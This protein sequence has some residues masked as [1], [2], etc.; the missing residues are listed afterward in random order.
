MKNL[1]E[2]WLKKIV[3]NAF[4]RVLTVCWSSLVICVPNSD[5]ANSLVL[6]KTDGYARLKQDGLFLES[7]KTYRFIVRFMGSFKPGFG[8]HIPEF[9]PGCWDPVFSD[10]SVSE[11]SE[12]TTVSGL[13]RPDVSSINL[14]TLAF[15]SVNRVQILSVQLLDTTTGENQ[16]K[17]ADFSEQMDDW[18]IDGGSASFATY[19][20]SVQIPSAPPDQT[21]FDDLMNYTRFDG[22]VIQLRGTETDTLVLLT[23]A[24]SHYH[25]P[26]LEILA[27]QLSLSWAYYQQTTGR[28]P[29]HGVYRAR[30]LSG[31]LISKPTLAVV[32][33]TCGPGCGLVG[34]IGIE[35]NTDVWLDTYNHLLSGDETRGVFEYEMGR[36][37]W[38]YADQIQHPSHWPYHYATAFATIMGYK[39][40]VFAG[41]TEEPGYELVDWVASYRAAFDA[42]LNKPNWDLIWN[43]G[44]SSEKILGGLW[45]FGEEAFGETYLPAFF[46]TLNDL[47]T[48]SQDT[49]DA[50]DNYV[51]AASMAAQTDLRDFFKNRLNFPISSQLDGRL[52]TKGFP[53]FDFAA[54]QQSLLPELSLSS[55]TIQLHEGSSGEIIVQRDRSEGQLDFF[56]NIETVDE[57]SREDVNKSGSIRILLREG[58]TRASINM[59]AVD[60]NHAEASEFVQVSIVPSDLFKVDPDRSSLRLEIVP[61]DY[62][63]NQFET[64]GE[65]S[66]QQ[67]IKNANAANESVTID[68]S[69]FKNQSHVVTLKETLIISGM[70][71][72]LGPGSKNLTIEGATGAGQEIDGG[73]LVWVQ[74]A[75]K[76]SF[77]RVTFKGGN[78]GQGGGIKNEGE[79]SLIQV[80]LRDGVA[81][82]DGGG[83]HSSGT[84][85]VE[86]CT[87]IGNHAKEKG[88]AIASPGKCVIS[89]STFFGN[90]SKHGGGLYLG[91]SGPALFHH[92]TV[93]QN[94]ASELGGGIHSDSSFELSNSLVIGNQAGSLDNVSGAVVESGPNRLSLSEGLELSQVL[95]LEV[96]DSADVPVLLLPNRSPA[97]NA[98]SEFSLV[99]D[100]FDLDE[101]GVLNEPVPF[102]Q[103]GSGYFRKVGNA[104]DLGAVESQ[105]ASS[106]EVKISLM[107]DQENPSSRSH[108]EYFVAFSEP[109]TVPMAEQFVL[110]GSG[111]AKTVTVMPVAGAETTHYTVEIDFIGHKGELRLMLPSG[112]V[113]DLAGNPNME[114]VF[115]G[116][117]LSYEPALHV[118]L[119]R[120]VME[121][122]EGPIL[123]EGTLEEVLDQDLS[124]KCFLFNTTDPNL[125]TPYGSVK[126]MI[127]P[128]G[129]LRGHVEW[130]VEDNQLLEGD[131]SFNVELESPAQASVDISNELKIQVLEDE[132]GTFQFVDQTINIREDRGTLQVLIQFVA[133]PGV[134]LGSNTV[135]NLVE[136]PSG[137]ATG[138]GN[139]FFLKQSTATFLKGAPGSTFSLFEIG[140]VDD[141]L[142]ERLIETAVFEIEVAGQED[143]DS[144]TASDHSL[145]VLIED[146]DVPV[147]IPGFKLLAVPEHI[148]SSGVRSEIPLQV[149]EGEIKLPLARMEI[150]SNYQELF[151]DLAVR[152][153]EADQ[154][155]NVV[156]ET[157]PNASGIAQITLDITDQT[158]IEETLYFQ[159][160]VS[161]SDEPLK[162]LQWRSLPR[163]ADNPATLLI[164]WLGNKKL[165][166]RSRLNGPGEPIQDATSPFSVETSNNQHF[167]ELRA[168]ND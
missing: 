11:D 89:N 120:Q 98:G 17:N 95:S 91:G 76:V 16:I 4:F 78:A 15:W 2:R 19:D 117:T 8:D 13:F 167:F 152:I 23:P 49:Q 137:T 7:G 20:S 24:Q 139:D 47:G 90:T 108:V 57:T 72:I 162:E 70:V 158:G 125:A 40:G 12:I 9:C 56:V 151:S 3:L 5:A 156:L 74:D 143:N 43:G 88:G 18:F 130:N 31:Q 148:I 97:I 69:A 153:D 161:A 128:A 54:Y 67:A 166:G 105:D 39:A 34:S 115:V 22:Q 118:T 71:T 1:M 150:A 60:D 29:L 27:A 122:G 96:D 66:L 58:Q 50:V 129:F 38:L 73:R 55:S 68:L 86:G 131:R 164:S 142:V 104:L 160:G 110:M 145:T 46:R 45:L 144:L 159:I 112:S 84:I 141:D 146:N 106:P 65:G 155:L 138:N 33:S 140:V 82:G 61:N 127:I 81:R 26:H 48:P 113:A 134:A 79:C 165:Y 32:G 51:Y 75:S 168:T 42:Y 62:G 25:K 63:V 80:V 10:Y 157:R 6:E 147:Q 119:E 126:S 52:N 36:N 59:S 154:S 149:A 103:R 107:S 93:S 111:V 116:E 99:M 100:R 94:H 64:D 14:M 28:E 133:E 101:D 35:I 53:P 109:V 121:E 136:T 44:Q 123:L 132:K 114:S 30:R 135:V 124:M 41:S 87:F 85:Y 102:D 163:S 37:F 21:Q 77:S 83:V 92:L